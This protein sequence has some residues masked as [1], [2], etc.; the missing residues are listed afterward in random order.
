[1][2]SNRFN[3]VPRVELKNAVLLSNDSGEIYKWDLE[4]NIANLV[5]VLSEPAKIANSFNN[6]TIYP[7]DTNV[8]AYRVDQT[9]STPIQNPGLYAVE[10]NKKNTQERARYKNISYF[11]TGGLLQE[12]TLTTLCNNKDLSNDDL[13][14]FGDI[15]S[16]IS[17][18]ADQQDT[19]RIS[20]VLTTKGEVISFDC[21]SPE[22]SA[23]AFR[24]TGLKFEGEAQNA[25]E[26][27]GFAGFQFAV[28]ESGEFANLSLKG[29]S[30]II[31]QSLDLPIEN[32]NWISA[33]PISKPKVF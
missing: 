24:Q 3:K 17:V 11:G 8:D 7:L 33:A 4:E 15:Q 6:I 5:T 20:A 13:G 2:A 31:N 10:Y 27:F 23:V 14:R 28:L 21:V 19:E 32:S 25:V 22:S 12:N 26:S 1:M 18:S 30:F 9:F 29:S 16:I